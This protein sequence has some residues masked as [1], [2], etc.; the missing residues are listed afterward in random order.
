MG[1][2]SQFFWC[3]KEAARQDNVVLVFII[4]LTWT[5]GAKVSLHLIK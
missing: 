2:G 5:N 4:L 1:N 3:K